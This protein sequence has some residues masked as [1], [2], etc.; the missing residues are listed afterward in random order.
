[1]ALRTWAEQR[2]R[3][4]QRGFR[5]RRAIAALSPGDPLS[6]S[7]DDGQWRVL[8]REGRQVG[9]MARGWA[10]P[11]G[12]AIARA[13]AQGIFTRWADDEEDEERQR[14]PRSETWE[15]VVPQW[16]PSREPSAAMDKPSVGPVG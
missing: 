9:R 14:T 15:V 4:M 7:R 10:L 16:F 13:S 2:K 11:S 12:M 3:E 6:V 1:M 5:C 8:D